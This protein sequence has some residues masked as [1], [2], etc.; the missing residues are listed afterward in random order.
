MKTRINIGIALILLW[1]SSCSSS[2]VIEYRE[3]S[4]SQK[5][6]FNTQSFDQKGHIV[7]IDHTSLNATEIRISDSVLYCSILP[8]RQ[9]A[10]IPLSQIRSVEF[11]RKSGP[12]KVGALS[13]LGLSIGALLSIQNP[14]ASSAEFLALPV[15]GAG[16]GMGVGLSQHASTKFTF[17]DP[18]RSDTVRTLRTSRTITSISSNKD[19]RTVHKT[20]DF[21]DQTSGNIKDFNFLAYQ[22]SGT[23]L[24]L[25]STNFAG[26]DFRIS[27][28]IMTWIDLSTQKK[29]SV[30]FSGIQS[31]DIIKKSDSRDAVRGG[32][33][34]LVLAGIAACFVGVKMISSAQKESE[35]DEDN[36]GMVLG[37][38][39]MAGTIVGVAAMAGLAT[40]ASATDHDT[41]ITVVFRE[42]AGPK[43]KLRKDLKVSAI[44]RDTVSVS[45]KGALADSA[46]NRQK[47]NMIS[48]KQQ[49]DTNQKQAILLSKQNKLVPSEKTTFGALSWT[50]SNMVLPLYLASKDLPSERLK[51]LPRGYAFLIAPSFGQ[52]YAHDKKRA[53]IGLSIR[54]GGAGLMGLGR[55]LTPKNENVSPI[56]YVGAIAVGTGIIYSLY[57]T[58]SS[59]REHN[60]RR[61]WSVAPVV[62]PS[63]KSAF[64]NLQINF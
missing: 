57:T 50:I 36:E 10:E 30:P 48:D 25:D 45:K 5:D 62:D 17:P 27:D 44:T 7:K 6:D 16:I 28:S 8:D 56:Y 51:N 37:A 4:Y 24:L 14:G 22:R 41:R 3:D 15:V 55:L 31:V 26:R 47:Q 35:E 63:G 2:R 43:S 61:S 18:V 39:V 40:G 53:I 60:A 59:V 58:P 29:M 42:P 38:A 49:I 23:V 33:T 12:V 46:S 1:L 21:T 19:R 52:I 11:I 20:I 54:L 9:V 32:A 64:L 34:G 13:L